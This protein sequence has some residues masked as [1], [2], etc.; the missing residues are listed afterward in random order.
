VA[1]ETCKATLLSFFGSTMRLRLADHLS[2]LAR[3][4]DA[5]PNLTKENH[6]AVSWSIARPE[7]GI[8]SFSG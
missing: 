6:Q 1:S 4:E 3:I 5:W 8:E 7:P 2:R